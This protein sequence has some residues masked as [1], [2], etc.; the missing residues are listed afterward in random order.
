MVLPEDNKTSLWVSSTVIKTVSWSD[1]HN[2]TT[3]RN[4]KHSITF[5]IREKRRLSS[6]DLQRRTSKAVKIE[7][8]FYAAGIVERYSHTPK[9]VKL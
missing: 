6:S 7:Q 1:L 4:R 8:E 2:S 9:I 3:S 5:W